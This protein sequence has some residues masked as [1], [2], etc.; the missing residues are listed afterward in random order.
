[1]TLASHTG[2]HFSCSPG[3]MARLALADRLRP[4]ARQLV[5][6]KLVKGTM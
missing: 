4:T 6:R 5:T 1:M 2:L 3:E